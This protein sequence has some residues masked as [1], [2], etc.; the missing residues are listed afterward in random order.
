MRRP[1]NSVKRVTCLVCSY[2][3][4]LSDMEARRKRQ[5]EERDRLKSEEEHR[6]KQEIETKYVRFIVQLQAASRGTRI[7]FCSL[8]RLQQDGWQERILIDFARWQ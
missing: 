6:R 5:E 7:A 2:I 4:R 3:N 1:K 8:L